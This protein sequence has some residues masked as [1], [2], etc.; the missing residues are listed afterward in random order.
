MD[1]AG[2][3]AE[4]KRLDAT[5]DDTRAIFDATHARYNTIA[6][7]SARRNATPRIKHAAVR[8]KKINA[9]KKDLKSKKHLKFKTP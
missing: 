6:T 7:P 1:K 5:R 9:Q 2:G 4:I 3:Q 8:M